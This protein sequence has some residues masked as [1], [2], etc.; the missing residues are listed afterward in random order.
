MLS[1]VRL[2]AI[3]WTVATRLLCPW[4]SPGNY[5]RVGCHSLLQGIFPTQGSNIGLLHYRQILYHLSH[6]GSH[7]EPLFKF[8]KEFQ[9]YSRYHL[10]A[11]WHSNL[12]S[13]L[14]KSQ[15]ECL[16]PRRAG[17][18]SSALRFCSRFCHANSSSR[19]FTRL[20]GTRPLSNV[21]ALH[22][23]EEKGTNEETEDSASNRRRKRYHWLC[24]KPKKLMPGITV[25]IV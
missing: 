22:L 21:I 12:A 20:Q 10:P 1:C 14:W 5:P 13:V 9:T 8:R 3:S 15:E 17:P 18:V 7:M 16:L 11:P 2:F 19:P 24:P 25:S 23:P 4:S 6:Q